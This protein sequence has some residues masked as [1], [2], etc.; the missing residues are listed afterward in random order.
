MLEHGVEAPERAVHRRGLSEPQRALILRPAR[1]RDNNPC[2]HDVQQHNLMAKR[3]RHPRPEYHDREVTQTNDHGPDQVHR[4]EAQGL[5]AEARA[6]NGPALFHKVKNEKSILA[7]VISN[8][9]VFAGTQGGELL[10]KNNDRLMN[11]ML[12]KANAN[13]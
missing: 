5:T 3:D 2:F 6:I 10:V 7:I 12:N 1:N 13:L 4:N 11:G 9:R 8:S